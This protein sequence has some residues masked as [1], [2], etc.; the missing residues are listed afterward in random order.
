MDPDNPIIKLCAQGMEAE[1]AGRPTEA[2]ECFRQAWDASTDPF[3][4]CIAAHYLARHQDTLE[5]T[6]NWNQLALDRANAAAGA[7]VAD[8]YPSLHLNLGKSHEDLGDLAQAR[9]HY[10][11]AAAHLAHVPESPYRAMIQRG[12]QAGLARTASSRPGE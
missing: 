6:L 7:R 8:F 10:E 3:E 5:A 2:R 1:G 9:T 12:I 11:H 4:A